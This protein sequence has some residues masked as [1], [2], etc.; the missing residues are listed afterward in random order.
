[1]EKKE[2][3]LRGKVFECTKGEILKFISEEENVEITSFLNGSISSIE[4]YC[5]KDF[6]V[7]L[8]EMIPVLEKKTGFYILDDQGK[9][10]F[11]W[12]FAEKNGITVKNLLQFFCRENLNEFQ[13]QANSIFKFANSYKENPI[14]R[15]KLILNSL[16]ESI[17]LKKRSVA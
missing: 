14:K 17:H 9:K 13:V 10:D 16:L 1:M 15:I 5:I 6:E 7:L 12:I 4:D 3:S 8:R 11:D 2:I